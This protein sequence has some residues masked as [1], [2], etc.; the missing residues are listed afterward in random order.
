MATLSDERFDA[1]KSGR[2]VEAVDAN[3]QD[4]GL[5]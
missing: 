5:R 4:A 2:H 3:A 1:V